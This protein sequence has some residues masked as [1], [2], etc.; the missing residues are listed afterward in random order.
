MKSGCVV[1]LAV[2]AT[3]AHAQE[4]LRFS[5]SA[6]SELTNDERAAIQRLHVVE[7]KE[8]GAFGI[9]VDTQGVNESTPGTSGGATLGGAIAEAAYI[10]R[11]FKP[12]NS[13]SAKSQLGAALL[14]AIV[15]SAMDAPPVQR[16]HFRYAIKLSNGEIQSHDSVQ[17][18]AFRLPAGICVGL[19]DLTQLPQAV[20]LGTASDIR[21]MYFPQQAS[22]APSSETPIA[23]RLSVQLPPAPTSLVSCK[24]GSLAPVQTTQEKCN[25]IGGTAQ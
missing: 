23:E 11:A 19:P 5:R 9:I 14:G 4:L 21:R 8:P 18:S 22:P 17:S 2:V 13:Y 16:F 6:W 12:G 20:C 25:L 7:I 15:G 3:T 10:D 24:A 1:L